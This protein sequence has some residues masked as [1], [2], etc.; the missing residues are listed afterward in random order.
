MVRLACLVLIIAFGGCAGIGDGE[1]A[2]AVKVLA[3]NDF[4]G[5]LQASPETLPVGG[6]PLRAGGTVH[7]ATLVER[8]RAAH[9]NVAFVSA[10]DLIGATP[11][12]SAFFDDE[13][14][15]EAM[16]LMGLDFNGVGNHEFDR[17]VPHLRRLQEGGCPPGGC[18]SGLPFGGA[19]FR[20]LAANVIVRASGKPLLPAY[21]VKEYGGVKVAFIGLTLRQTPLIVSP[22]SIEGLEFRDEAETVD[23]LVGELR[24]EGVGAIVV[25][26]HQGGVT[27]GGHNE[28][29]DLSGPIVNLARRLHQA[30]NV[31]VSAHTHQAYI[32]RLGGKLVTSAGAYGRFVTEIDLKIDRS[33]REIVAASARNHVVAPDIAASGAQ[34]AL[35]ER[36]SKLAEPLERVVGRISG[37]FSR[38]TND[39]GESPL[40]QL[41]ADSHLEATRQAGAVAAFMNP[42]GIRAPLELKG[43][44]EIMFGDVFAVY[45]F[46]NRLVT[47]TLT[48]AQILR[49]LEQQ[50]QGRGAAMLQVSKGFGYAW[51]PRRPAGSRVVRD[52]VMIDGRPLQPDARY[53]ITVNSFN[54]GGG[55][56]LRVFLDGGERTAGMNARDALIHYMRERSPLAPAQDARVRKIAAEE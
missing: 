38:R 35:I 32:C 47:M 29:A 53:R 55:D 4:H 50:W 44:G 24:R 52:S 34:A 48:G 37:S 28:C 54:A 51:D 26:L 45:P 25:L 6:S 9:P 30:V 56:G 10:G 15:I 12:I 16:N 7:M 5:H 8:F 43:N 18:K 31:I 2:V 1:Q 39:D 42:G 19:R 36:Y 23:E 49:L 21:G 3:I 17:G 20:M 22:P 27:S 13:P 14:A 11:L 33:R 46:N 40:G 41:I